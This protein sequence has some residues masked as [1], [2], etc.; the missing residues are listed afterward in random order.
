ML[1][2][3]IVL[4]LLQLEN[5]NEAQTAA[6]NSSNHKHSIEFTVPTGQLELAQRLIKGIYQKEP[7]LAD[8]SPPHQ[9]QLLADR[10]AVAKVQ[11]AAAKALQAASA[12]W[13]W[14]TVLDVLDLPPSCTDQ[15]RFGPVTEAAV[16]KLQQ[17]QLGDLEVV[18]AEDQLQQQLLAL[19]CSTLLQLL[20]H[21]E[22]R[23]IKEYTV[24]YMILQWYQQ[25]PEATRSIPQ[26][27]QLMQQV[28]MQHV[29]ESASL[30][31]LLPLGRVS[32]TPKVP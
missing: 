9:L 28:R 17:Q 19:P 13:P 18:W 30:L 5:W 15:P 1:T 20:Q 2:E 7:V 16:T 24:V 32:H 3:L 26:V 25:Q 27:K 10:Y 6:C 29:G 31:L 14:Q 22:T 23:V 12:D 11:A 4:Q 21:N 8:L